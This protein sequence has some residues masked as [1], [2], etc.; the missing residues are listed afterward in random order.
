[1]GNTDWFFHDDIIISFKHFNNT[2]NENQKQKNDK[3]QTKKQ[4]Q[5]KT[6]TNKYS[7]LFHSSS[8][9]PPKYYI[10]KNITENPCTQKKTYCNSLFS[11]Q[12]HILRVHSST[13]R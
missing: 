13:E 9:P 11:N 2:D 4:K 1:M 3:R 12:Q 5:T 7:T 10:N 6:K 8:T